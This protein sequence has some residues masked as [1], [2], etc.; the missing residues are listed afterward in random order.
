MAQSWHLRQRLKAANA[1]HHSLTRAGRTSRTRL[2]ADTWLACQRLQQLQ[3]RAESL[4]TFPLAAARLRREL[5]AARLRLASELQNS[6]TDTSSRRGSLSHVPVVPDERDIFRDLMALDAEFVSTAV[7]LQQKTVSVDTDD[8]VLEDICLGP[9][10]ITLHWNDIGQH[11][12]SYRVTALAPQPSAVCASWVHPHVDGELLC[13]G[14]GKLA[15]ETALTQGR[16]G[17]F[18]I[19]VR[20]ILQT[21]SPG[22]AYAPLS[23]WWGRLCSGCADVVREHDLQTCELCGADVCRDC[24]NTCTGCDAVLCSDC[25]LACAQC[26]EETCSGCLTACDGCSQQLCERCLDHGEC[27]DCRSAEADEDEDHEDLEE[28]RASSQTAAPPRTTHAAI[29]PVCME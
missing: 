3:L 7:C 9:F 2:P 21:Y 13:A 23:D 11:V 18:F 28:E 22:N 5:Q 29:H 19:M 10:R 26:E 16:I 4:Q 14:D 12:R 6:A 20:Q 27:D 1:I 15:I 8:I 24:T 17:D 25:T